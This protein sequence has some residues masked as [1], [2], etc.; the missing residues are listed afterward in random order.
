MRRFQLFEFVRELVIE[1][2]VVEIAGDIEEVFREAVP[3]IG[4]ERTVLKKALDRFAHFLAELLVVHSRSRIPNDGECGRN[5]ALVGESVKRG[6]Q[7]ALGEIAI[8]AEDHNSAWRG[9]PLEAQ[10]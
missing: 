8:S 3:Q 1:L 7:L 4:F 9:A 5:A 2:R 6:H 10:G